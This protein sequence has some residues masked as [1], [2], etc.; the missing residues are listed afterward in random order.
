M[1]ALGFVF[2]INVRPESVVFALS[3]QSSVSAAGLHYFIFEKQYGLEIEVGLRG[4][5]S[6][7]FPGLGCYLHFLLPY[8]R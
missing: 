4:P 1:E 8:K 2:A 6:M 5:P 7:K 3:P